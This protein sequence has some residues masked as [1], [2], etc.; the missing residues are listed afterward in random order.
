MLAT[1]EPEFDHPGSVIYFGVEDIKS[2][3]RGSRRTRSDVQDDAAQS[4][5]AGRSGSVAGGFRG[6]RG[7][8][9]A[10]MSEPKIV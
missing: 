7:N 5:D 3:A 2:D 9:L 1:A 6:Y 10:L 8:T 4:G